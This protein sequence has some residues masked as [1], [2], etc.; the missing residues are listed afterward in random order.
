ML[1][2]SDPLAILKAH[3]DDPAAAM[4]LAR[5][6]GRKVVVRVGSAIPVEL[7]VA[8][9]LT[10][11]LARADRARPAP[12]AAE[13]IDDIVPPET[14]A[15]FEAAANGVFDGVE[16]LVLSRAYDKLFYYLKEV[17]RLGGMP[18]LPPL[19]VFDLMQT[20]RKAVASYNAGRLH[21]LRARLER[22]AERKITDADLREA[23]G[24]CNRVR[25][26][27]RM[28]LDLRWS[29]DVDGVTAMQ[30]IGAGYFMHPDDYAEALEQFL[31]ELPSM[32]R[33]PPC[34]RLLLA[35]SEPLSH[36]ALH[37]AVEHAGGTIVAE[38]D[39]WGARA[40][41]GDVRT[42]LAP[43]EALREKYCTDAVTEHFY[44]VEERL[45]W[46]EETARRD[47]VDGVIFY[48]P[49][50]DL[51]YGWDYPRL[52]DLVQRA[53]KPVLLI[54][55]DVAT[56]AGRMHLTEQADLFVE[57]LQASAGLV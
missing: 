29:G 47:D 18:G 6:S 49:P 26:R 32:P 23:I 44:P 40:P 52:R 39:W 17:Y 19:H 4:E 37:E 28:L 41:G 50:S 36:V 56:P 16:L 7:I 20:P 34:R 54:R 2:E 3:Y 1:G 9:G 22:S 5:A 25:A 42:D 13:Y 57:S 55:Q 30:L 46:F 53:G 8:A 35:T 12:I 51:Q 15:L 24:A 45:A 31:V 10:P 43:M 33:R 27:Q 48:I 11:F 14:H 38:D 21:E